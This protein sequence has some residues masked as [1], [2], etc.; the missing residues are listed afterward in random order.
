MVLDSYSNSSP[1]A[2][3]RHAAPAG[4]GSSKS[5]PSL[6]E[7]DIRSTQDLERAFASGLDGEAIDRD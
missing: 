6:I 1:E 3:R 7:G 4:L 5:G 2:P